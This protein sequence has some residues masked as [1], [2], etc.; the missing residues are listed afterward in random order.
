M[1]VVERKRER[2]QAK[3]HELVQH[4]RAVLAAAE[5]G[6][7][8]VCARAPRFQL[9]NERLEIGWRFETTLRLIP[10]LV[11][12][13]AQAA[14]A[15]GIELHVRVIGRNATARAILNGLP[16]SP[17]PDDHDAVINSRMAL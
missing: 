17:I 12:C 8:V 3:R 11:V 7:A 4:V 14:H 5:Q 2:L 15:L 6:K 16:S 10:K 9:L 13:D 1:T